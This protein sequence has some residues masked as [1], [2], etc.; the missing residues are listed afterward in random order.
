[1]QVRA[2]EYEGFVEDADWVYRWKDHAW[3]AKGVS[4]FYKPD[5]PVTPSRI[6][7]DHILDRL[8]IKPELRNAWCQSHA[9]ELIIQEFQGEWP[10]STPQ[11][12]RNRRVFRVSIGS[13]WDHGLYRTFREQ[14]G[15]VRDRSTD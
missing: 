8:E 4:H 12:Y 2:L 7:M 15:G 10:R 14:V 1:M 9:E 3:G 13:M 11:E 6:V 5:H